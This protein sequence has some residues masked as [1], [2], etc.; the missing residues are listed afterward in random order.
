MKDR[1]QKFLLFSLGI[2]IVLMALSYKLDTINIQNF[3]STQEKFEFDNNVN[4]NSVNIPR[5][6]DYTQH[7]PILI[8]SNLDFQTK[9]GIEGWQ[10]TGTIGNPYRIENYYITNILHI[11]AQ[12]IFESS[13]IEDWS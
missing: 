2:L 6:Q 4:I 5:T 11:Q 8:T 12:R 1:Q 13:K 10:G 7:A 3:K 9:A